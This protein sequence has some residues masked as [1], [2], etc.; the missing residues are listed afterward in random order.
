[1]INTEVINTQM[2]S[3][4][5]GTSTEMVDTEMV[6]TGRPVRRAL[7]VVAA[8]LLAAML[9]F[10]G[11]TARAD[12]TGPDTQAGRYEVRFLTGMID[13]HQMAVMMGQTCL[14]K[15]DHPD[16][17]ALC[18]NIIDSQSQQIQTMQTWLADWYGIQHQPELTTGDQKRMGRLQ[19][20]QGVDYEIAFMTAMIRHHRRAVRE[21]TTCTGRAEHEQLIGLCRNIVGSQQAQIVQMETWLCQWYDRCGHRPARNA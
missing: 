6:H 15:A 21:G 5:E 8:L 14:D 7:A 1:M 13:H 4:T 20:L 11:G 9:V 17:L 18:Q 19:R 2:I 3:S 10:N 12:P 16:L